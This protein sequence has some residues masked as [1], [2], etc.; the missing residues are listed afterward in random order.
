MDSDDEMLIRLLEDQ[1][2]F[3]NDLWEH[4]LIVASLQDM[5]DTEAKKRKRPRRGGSRPGRKKLKPR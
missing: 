3:D 2:D 1:Q 4:L 5:L